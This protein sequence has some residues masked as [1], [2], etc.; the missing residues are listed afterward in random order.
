MTSIRIDD[1]PYTSEGYLKG[2]KINDEKREKELIE[3]KNFVD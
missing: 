1:W 2:K 3:L